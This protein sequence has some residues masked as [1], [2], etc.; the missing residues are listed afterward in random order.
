VSNFIIGGAESAAMEG[1]SLAA[2]KWAEPLTLTDGES[3]ML[4]SPVG[5]LTGGALFW[6]KAGFLF[7]GLKTGWW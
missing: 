1:S 5:R 3:F 4:E 2:T 7:A 6:G